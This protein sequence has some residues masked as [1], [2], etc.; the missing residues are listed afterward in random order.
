M[1][2]RLPN[3]RTCTARVEEWYIYTFLNFVLGWEGCVFD[4]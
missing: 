3:E 4:W 2:G 1:V